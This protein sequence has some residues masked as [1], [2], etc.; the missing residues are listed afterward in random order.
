MTLIFVTAV[1]LV[2]LGAWCVYTD[3][4]SLSVKNATVCKAALLFIGIAGALGAVISVIVCNFTAEKGFGLSTFNSFIIA[5]GVYI[6]VG[7]GV[8][9]LSS[10]LKTKMR[11]VIVIVLP[12]WA[13]I[14]LFISFIAAFWISFSDPS[15]AIYASAFGISGAAILA[16][17]AF[18]EILAR[19]KLLSDDKMRNEIIKRREAKKNKRKEQKEKKKK[20]AEKKKRLKNPGR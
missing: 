5:Y 2:L 18:L 11:A 13:F 19:E 14:G 17:P 16:F 15:C 7:F 9:F 4:V 1:F 3:F 8:T 20:L 12:L 10:V 6:I